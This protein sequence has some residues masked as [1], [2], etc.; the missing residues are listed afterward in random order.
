MRIRLSNYGYR[1]T[2]VRVNSPSFQGAEMRALEHL[3]QS[4]LL[5]YTESATEKQLLE[6]GLIE[7]VPDDASDEDT[8]LR[9]IRNPLENIDLVNFEMTTRCNLHCLHC[10]SGI[11]KRRTE[12]D[13][14]ALKSAA[15]RFLDLGVIRF[16]FIGGEVSK[17][18]DGWLDL[19]QH[20]HQ[21]YRANQARIPRPFTGKLK[22]ALLTSGWW[23]EQTDF[24]AA[25]RTY[26]SAT[27]Y[28]REMK[29]SGLTHI[30]FS[31]D[32]PEE[33]HDVWRQTPGLYRRILR[34][35]PQAYAAGL[36]PK[37]S[38]VVNTQEHVRLGIDYLEDVVDLLYDL[39]NHMAQDER[40]AILLADPMNLVSNFIDINS[41]VQLREGRFHL[42]EIDPTMLRC[43][44]FYRPAPKI[45][46]ATSG[47]IAICPLMNAAE[48]YGNIHERR[49]VDV[50]NTLDENFVFRLHAD[51]SIE[52]YL[53]L[54]DTSI[55]GEYFDHV[56]SLRII[57]N[58]LA[59]GMKEQ[60]LS[61]N[62]VT[63][64]DGPR[65]AQI[66]REVARWTGHLAGGNNIMAGEA[67]SGG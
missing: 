61:P 42:S 54:M 44:A 11:L 65:L 10:R 56:C 62:S 21:Y 35:I 15:E 25:G 52:A 3:Q 39:P 8:A 53:P 67:T 2:S 48:K 40:M 34:G 64:A 55:F 45:S 28:L 63:N 50:L 16:I 18:G 36:I 47:E 32:G 51:R 6:R 19:V 7:L 41:G 38:L 23:L 4:L 31:I 12:T 5:P 57:L 30:L 24:E 58:L 37:V 66:N 46:I 27:T 14:D 1:Y 17:Y 60:G 49:L 22:I 9:Y 33:L 20:I 29:K 26:E 43:K 59:I 13:I